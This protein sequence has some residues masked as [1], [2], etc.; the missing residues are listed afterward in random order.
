LSITPA[1][2][3][4][5]RALL[6]W[7]QPHLAEQ[8]GIHVQTISTFEQANSSPSQKTLNCIQN[9]LKQAGIEFQGDTGV[10][11]Q[12]NTVIKLTGP[13]GFSD[14]LDDVYETAVTYGTKEKPVQVYLSNVVHEN[15]IKW[16]GPQ[17]WKNH[18]DRMTKNKDVMDVRIIVREGDYNFPAIDYSQYKWFSSDVFND[19]SF[20]SYHD[21]LAFLHFKEN[22]VEILIMKNAEFAEGYRTLFTMAWDKGA[23]I[24]IKKSA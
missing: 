19:K 2:C 15:W 11:L 8:A 24:P 4:A 17:K 14:F 22:D 12:S 23:M 3:R 18:T 9:A 6:N 7:S 5:A 13:E 16:M 20:Y 21:K 10:K 1:Q